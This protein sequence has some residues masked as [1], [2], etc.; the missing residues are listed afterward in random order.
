MSKLIIN[1]GRPL[2]GTVSPVANKNSILKLIRAAM[3]TDEDVTIHNVP[4]TSDVK[5]MIAL[6]R[7]LGATVETLNDG[8]TLKINCKG[9]NTYQLDEEISQALK[10]SV[11]FMGP[12]LTRFGKADMPIPG[13]CKLG[14]RPLDSFIEN[15]EQLSVS[16]IRD[17]GYWP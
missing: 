3:L 12:L 9:I 14:T 6:L 2:R 16:C 15:M 8:E 17:K 4:K 10:T 7:K 13:G 11:M 1:G 5:Y